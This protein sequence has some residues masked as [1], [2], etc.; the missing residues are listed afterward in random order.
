[1]SE[2]AG[3]LVK[4]HGPMVL[5]E[6]AKC[7]FRTTDKVL[8]AQGHSRKDLGAVGSPQSKAAREKK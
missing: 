8:A 3:E 6:I 2:M 5:T 1:V 4:K 7:H